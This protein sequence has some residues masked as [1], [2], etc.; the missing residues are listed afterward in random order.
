MIQFYFYVPSYN[1]CIRKENGYSCVQ[2]TP[3]SEDKS[4]TLSTI[5]KEDKG[6]IGTNCSLDF[7]E[8]IGGAASCGSTALINRYCG[9]KFSNAQEAAANGV[10]CGMYWLNKIHAGLKEIYRDN[11]FSDCTAPF[12]VNY[13]TSSKAADTMGAGVNRG[14]CINRHLCIL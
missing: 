14:K 1:I 9:N 5:T 6:E 4:F 3:C 11:Y 7:V 2:Y 12:T 13:F 8:I 10:V